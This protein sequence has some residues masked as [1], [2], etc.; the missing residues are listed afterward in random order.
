[1]CTQTDGSSRISVTPTQ[2]LIVQLIKTVNFFMD[3]EK[4][5]CAECTGE[6][7]VNGY[8][9]N[10]GAGEKPEAE[11]DLSAV[12]PVAEEIVT[13]ESMAPEMV[14]PII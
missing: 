6:T 5:I 12:V 10:C 7:V 13:K 14:E 8:C 1:M 11:D 2:A 3:N 9:H 4:T